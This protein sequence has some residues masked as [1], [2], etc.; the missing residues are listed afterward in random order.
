MYRVIESFTDM[1]DN[2]HPYAVGD[3]FPRKN[4][5]VPKERIIELSTANNR[6]KKPVIVFVENENV[7]VQEE[8]VEGESL[9]VNNSSKGAK[10]SAAKKG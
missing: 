5:D 8:V 7:E 4:F 9:K 6:R 1:Q 10:S 3:T 2:D